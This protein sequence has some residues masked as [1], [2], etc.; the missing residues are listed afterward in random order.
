M[1]NERRQFAIF[2]NFTG[3]TLDTI[4]LFNA[5]KER[6]SLHLSGTPDIVEPKSIV[7][8]QI[9]LPTINVRPLLQSE[10]KLTN[11]VIGTSRINIEQNMQDPS[12]F[13]FFKDFVLDV[14]N[15]I[16]SSYDVKIN[17]LALN[18][19][20]FGYEE[21]KYLIF[22][23]KIFK[24]TLLYDSSPAEWQFRIN[25]CKANDI[26]GCDINQIISFSKGNFVF[27]NQVEQESLIVSY[28]YNTKQGIS[29]IFVADDLGK[30]IDLAIEYRNKVLSF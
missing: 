18:G 20:L 6:Y 16:T 26:M 13:D 15:C 4:D 3:I 11:I 2:G 24:E 17:R 23:N 14:C 19:Q 27:N 10:D 9:G 5:I 25:T 12:D 8:L 21:D 28:D 30:F 22:Y 1:L 29:K 7:N